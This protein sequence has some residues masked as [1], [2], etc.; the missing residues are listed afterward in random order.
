MHRQGVGDAIYEIVLSVVT[1]E[2][3]ERDH[4][5]GTDRFGATR[6]PL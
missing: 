2:V 5:E 1:R 6:I 4:E 3:L